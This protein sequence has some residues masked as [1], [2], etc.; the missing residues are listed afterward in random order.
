MYPIFQKQSPKFYSYGLKSH[1]KASC[2]YLLLAFLSSKASN[3]EQPL[4]HKKFSSWLLWIPCP[5]VHMHH[6]CGTKAAS[7]FDIPLVHFWVWIHE[8][9]CLS[10]DWVDKLI[11]SCHQ[12]WLQLFNICSL[13][14]RPCGFVWVW[15]LVFFQKNIRA[16]QNL[17]N[18]LKGLPGSLGAK[19]FPIH[20]L[21]QKKLINIFFKNSSLKYASKRHISIK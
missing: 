5:Y 20:H 13:L 8:E 16:L 12:V 7:P 6:I 10:K 19:K 15:K 21:C 1:I 3:H 18:G 11:P 2:T 4:F 17:E 9:T 14:V